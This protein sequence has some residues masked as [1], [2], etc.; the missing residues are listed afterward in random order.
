MADLLGDL[1]EAAAEFRHEAD[2]NRSWTDG[3]RSMIGAGEDY[4]NRRLEVAAERDRW[5]DAIQK[6]IEHLLDG[7]ELIRC[8]RE[9]MA[10]W[11]AYFPDDGETIEDATTILGVHTAEHAAREAVEYDFCSRDG[12]ERQGEQEFKVIVVSPDGEEFEYDGWHEPTLV[13]KARR[14]KKPEVTS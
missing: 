6:A 12:W 2:F 3:R 7:R 8:R 9:P 14:V 4:I 13:H 10:D 11:R 5:A 1:A